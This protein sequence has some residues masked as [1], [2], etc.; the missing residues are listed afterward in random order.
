MESLSIPILLRIHRAQSITRRQLCK[1]TGLSDGRISALVGRLLGQRLVREDVRQD[2]KPGRPAGSLSVNP[3]TGRVVGLD[4]G[5]AH[6][7][8]VVSDMAGHV[9]ASLVQS[10][11]A[12]PDRAVIVDNIARLVEAVCGQVGMGSDELAALGV[13]VQGIINSQTGVVLDWPNTPDWAAAWRGLDLPE[14]LY[15]RLGSGLIVVDDSVRAMGVTAHR[16][17]AARGSRNFFYVFLG[18]GIGGAVF[19]DGHLYRGSSGLAGE[20][21]HVAIEE[22]GL[23]CNC[24]NRGCLE[25]LASTSA[26][27]RR[28]RERLANSQVSS[29]LRTPYEENEPTLADLIQAA[30]TGD[31]LAF[32]VLD[33]AATYIGRV[34]A[35]AL[36]L[37]GPE[38]VVLGGPLSQADHIILAAVRHQVRL[39]ALQHVSN[40]VH[41]VCDD[42]GEMAGARGAALL[43][44][45]ALFASGKQVAALLEKRAD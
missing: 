19:V 3:D 7:R 25:M 36:N 24:G 15:A 18:N 16:F 39:H 5:G 10:T 17:G 22:E 44:L 20:L 29:T 35:I 33:E 30:R 31:K 26:V 37:L 34:L 43:A 4:I 38:L 21:G 28:V 42:Q 2:G 40:Q 8:A 32:Q 12:V 13:G 11:Q 45:D 41:I 27:I 14:E 9:L 6:S 23:W 1:Q